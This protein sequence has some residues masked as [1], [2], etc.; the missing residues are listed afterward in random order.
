M[1]RDLLPSHHLTE[2]YAGN[3]TGKPS[4]AGSFRGLYFATH[5]GNYF[6]NAPPAQIHV[7]LEDMA[8]W[9]A[10]TLVVISEAAKFTN[11]SA[12]LPLLDRNARIG[13]FAQVSEQQRYIA[14]GWTEKRPP[15]HPSPYSITLQSHTRA[16]NV[17]YDIYLY[18]YDIIFER[19]I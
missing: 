7:Y 11:F 6:A 3:S 4:K 1:G 12:L 2:L 13:A 16:R 10:N 14:H 18:Y 5:F 15:V 9:G 17:Y 8:L 19:Y